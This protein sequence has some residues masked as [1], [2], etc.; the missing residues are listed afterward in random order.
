MAT[1]AVPEA[2]QIIPQADVGNIVFAQSAQILFALDVEPFDFIKKV[3]FK[4]GIDVCLDG[5]G[6]R[7]AFAFVALK[8]RQ[9]LM[10]AHLKE[11]GILPEQIVESF[12]TEMQKLLISDEIRTV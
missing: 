11:T 7:C 2:E 12:C 8:Q 4:Q 5:V 6:T 3:A 1:V 10:V 9:K